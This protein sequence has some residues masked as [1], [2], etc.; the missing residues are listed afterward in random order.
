MQKQIVPCKILLD[1]WYTLGHDLLL[2]SSTLYRYFILIEPESCFI[3]PENFGTK[4]YVSFCM[5]VPLQP[6]FVVFLSFPRVCIFLWI[7]WRSTHEIFAWL[8]TM[9]HVG[10]HPGEHSWLVLWQRGSSWCKPR[11]IKAIKIWLSE[12]VCFSNFTLNVLKHRAWVL[13]L[14]C[15]SF[16]L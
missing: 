9:K 7:V 14:Y 8:F 4:K 2:F 16:K 10:L 13:K 11:K 15:T 12:V 3:S 5:F 6:T 1:R